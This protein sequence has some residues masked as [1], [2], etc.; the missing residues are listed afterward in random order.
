MQR[1]IGAIVI[2]LFTYQAQADLT[3]AKNR[4]Q[5]ATP[6]EALV[7]SEDFQNPALH[8]GSTWWFTLTEMQAKFDEIYASGKR[9]DMRAHYDSSKKG[10]F[11]LFKNINDE[12]RQVPITENFINSVTKHV[13]NALKKGY[14]D[15][16]FLPDMGHSHFYFPEE[17]WQK[18]YPNESI[19]TVDL[20]QHYAKMMA[21]TE[22][23]VLYHMAEKLLGN[24]LTNDPAEKA[25]LDFR[26]WNRN[27]FGGNKGGDELQIFVDKSSSGNAV[28]SI[29]GYHDWS[30][31]FNISASKDGCFPFQWK[32]KTYYFDL[33]LY[34][35]RPEHPEFA[36]HSGS[37][38]N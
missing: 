28:S 13:E 25:K 16:I 6:G 14:A 19:V 32:G 12:I 2:A 34:D 17:H 8:K 10:F 24:S 30:A 27:V 9:L 20:D 23:H 36:S 5:M 33:S 31:G 26:F 18:N 38:D 7:F 11:L 29:E 21:D 15:H 35:L 1:T 3:E 37:P 22:L 4:C